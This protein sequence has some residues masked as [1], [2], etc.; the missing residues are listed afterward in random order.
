MLKLVPV[1]GFSGCLGRSG[2]GDN[3]TPNAETDPAPSTESESEPKRIEAGV[4]DDFEDLSKWSTSGGSV[5][6]DTAN[7]ISGSQSVLLDARLKDN[8]VT[9]SR[10]F[11]PPV[12]ISGLGIQCA[13]QS[14]TV[15]RPYL[16]A[17]DNN[18]HR[19][20]FRTSVNKGLSFQTF[21]FGIGTVQGEPNP[22]SI[23]EIRF[24]V[25][26]GDER[27]AR[28][29]CDQLSFSERPDTGIVLVH[30]DD[31]SLSDYTKAFPVLEEYGYSASTFI[32][33]ETLGSDGRIS[34]DELSEL[35]EAGW[36]ICNHTLGHEN[37]T[38]LSEDEQ[39]EQIVG[40]KE[41]LVDH[42]FEKGAEYFTYPYSSYNQT[43]L[44]IVSRHHEVG[45]AGGFPGYGKVGN[46][47]LVQRISADSQAVTKEIDLAAEMNG[48]TTLLYHRLSE[49]HTNRSSASEFESTISYLQ[50]RESDGDLKVLSVSE[51]SPKY[52]E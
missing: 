40:A 30:F 22:S 20:D 5:T 14:D 3:S 50:E 38:N 31:G 9:L 35:Q 45:F 16:M 7:Y 37:L 33:P 47:Y 6:V 15:I 49:E 26:V 36:D 18:G 42:G 34:L 29:W 10:T 48:V 13:I 8:H 11:D 23:K 17:F 1:A 28:V 2:S 27:K 4:F 25:W 46:Q 39:F 52:L 51:F 24:R 43:S 44:D 32:N 21:D 12:D 41:W 19:I